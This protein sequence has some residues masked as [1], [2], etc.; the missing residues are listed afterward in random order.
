MSKDDEAVNMFFENYK[1]F[2]LTDFTKL[3]QDM[4]I[5]IR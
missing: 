5:A 3:C 1:P 4:D 2:T